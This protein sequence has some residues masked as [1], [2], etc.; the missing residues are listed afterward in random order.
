MKQPYIVLLQTESI[1][2]ITGKPLTTITFVGCKDRKEYVTYIDVSN[3]NHE[4][5][6][7]VLRNPDSGFCISNVKLKSKLT[8]K[9]QGIVNADSR[10]RIEAEYESL[11]MMLAEIQEIWAEQDRK[12]DSDRYRDLF[13]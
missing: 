11:D 6:S 13:E 10:F 1:S 4:H 12:D 9:G 3:H 7:H 2:R 8:K 5:W